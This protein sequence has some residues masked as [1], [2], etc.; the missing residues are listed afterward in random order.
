MLIKPI[1]NPE[2]KKPYTNAELVKKVKEVLDG[3]K[4]GTEEEQLEYARITNND[5]SISEWCDYICN[6]ENPTLQQEAISKTL[7]PVSNAK[8]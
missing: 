2:T 6:I 7:L 5:N 4:N 8:K 3:L 1:L